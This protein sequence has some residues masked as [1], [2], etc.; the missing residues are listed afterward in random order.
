MCTLGKNYESFWQEIVNNTESD[1]L[2]FQKVCRKC[3]IS[4]SDINA[5]LIR[6]LGVDGQD[7]IRNI[8]SLGHS[9]GEEPEFR[10]QK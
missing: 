8:R 10:S 4:P 5:L 3:R 7:F 6:E 1:T 9:R 2:S